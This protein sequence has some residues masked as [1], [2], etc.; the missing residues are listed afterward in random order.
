[1]ITRP[2][3]N[4]RKEQPYAAIRTQVPIP[5]GNISPILRKNRTQ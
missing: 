4:Y 2:K 5:F 1:M 3:L